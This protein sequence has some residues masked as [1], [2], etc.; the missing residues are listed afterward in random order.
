MVNYADKRVLHDLVVTL[1]DRFADLKQRYGRTPEALGR[2]AATEISSQA[3]EEKL[4]TPYPSPLGPS[5][6]CT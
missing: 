4:F 6:Y 5:R 1:A 3:L 2:I